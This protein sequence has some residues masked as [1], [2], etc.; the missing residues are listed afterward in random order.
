M[1][2]LSELHIW[3][4]PPSVVIDFMGMSEGRVE[5]ERGTNVER[6]FP[7]EM[8]SPKEN[9]FG[10]PLSSSLPPEIFSSQDRGS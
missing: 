8:N 10:P 3:M 5:R 1:T 2:S 7:P 9:N 6:G 4:A